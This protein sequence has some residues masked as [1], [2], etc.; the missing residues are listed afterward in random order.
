MQAKILRALEESKVRPVGS[1]HE[2]SVNVRL[3]TAT[4]RDLE[5][6]VEEQRFREDLF[7]RINVIQLELPPLRSRGMD[8]LL[9]A[10]H[11]VEQFAERAN[12]DVK[13]ISDQAAEK[14]LSYRWPGNVRELRNVV[15]RAVA[16]TRYENLAVDDLPDKI[17]NYRSSQLFIGGLDPSELVPMEEIER[18][19]II[20]VLDAVNDNKTLAARILGLD[21]K[22]LYRKLKT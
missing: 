14:L 18:R 8:V 5:T 12:K 20:H 22:T 2:V 7:Y 3:L 17:R 11:Y 4:N 10:R 1:N 19:Y 15:E 16:L 21:R 9:L 13:G 6:A